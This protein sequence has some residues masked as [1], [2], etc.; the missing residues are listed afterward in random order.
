MTRDVLEAVCVE[1]PRGCRL[2][3]RR[4]GGELTVSGAACP[5][6]EA[7]GRRELL[8]PARVLTGTVRT[9]SRDMPRLPVRTREAIP[10]DTLLEAARALSSIVAAGPLVPGD[11][12]IEDFKGLGVPLVA[13]AVLPPDSPP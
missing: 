8:A 11:T 2:S 9:T 6:G 13:T 1:C 4:S 3:V 10:L 7:W 12:V 5:R